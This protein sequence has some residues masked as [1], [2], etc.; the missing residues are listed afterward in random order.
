LFKLVWL[1]SLAAVFDPAGRRRS[2]ADLSELPALL[3]AELADPEQT[4]PVLREI[5]ALLTAGVP[6]VNLCRVDGLGDELFTYS[7]SGTLFTRERYVSVRRF[8][9]EAYDAAAD[10]IARGTADGY[11]APRT[12]AQIDTLLADGFGAF[13]G[14]EHLAGIG[15]L[16]V[17]GDA[18]EVAS[19]Y[20]LTRFAGGG[21]GKHLVAFAVA[22]A[23]ALNLSFVY[24]CTTFDRVGRFFVEQGFAPAPP[25]ALPAEKWRGYDETRRARLRC[26]RRELN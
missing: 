18:G 23:Q 24:A 7:G 6:C 14:G 13:V 8:G 12:E 26:F 25:E 16:R 22:Q 10:L 11:L 21:V 1:S 17:C 9:I 3:D 20:T 4:L 19:L 5:E 15:A 2:F